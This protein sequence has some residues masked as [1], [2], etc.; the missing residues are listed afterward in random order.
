MVSPSSPQGRQGGGKCLGGGPFDF[1]VTSTLASQT[2][3]AVGRAMGIKLA[4]RLLGKGAGNQDT[5]FL[6]A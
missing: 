5:L 2:P 3:P 1:Y 6:A 4:P